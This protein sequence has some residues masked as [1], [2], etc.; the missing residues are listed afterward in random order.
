[1]CPFKGLGP[2]WCEHEV[3]LFCESKVF[4]PQLLAK[5]LNWQ[6]GKVSTNG[7][8]TVDIVQFPKFIYAACSSHNLFIIYIRLFPSS[9]CDVTN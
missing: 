9:P 8:K 7:E 1:M 4:I 6:K 5:T 3:E 2:Y